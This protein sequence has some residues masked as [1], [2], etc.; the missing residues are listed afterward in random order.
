MSWIKM[1]T[2]LRDHPKVVRMGATL[3]A[4]RLRVIG[5]LWAVWSTF[6]THSI[7]GVLEGYT[8]SA[9][10][11]GIGWK[12]FA[13]AMQAVGWLVATESGLSVP[14]F[15]EHNGSSAKRRATDAKRKEVLRE[16][17]AGARGSWNTERQVSPLCPPSEVAE[18]A[19]GGGQMSASDADK[20]PPR[21]R[22][23]KEKEKEGIQEGS[24]RARPPKKP[25]GVPDQVWADWIALRKAKRA[26][27]TET[28]IAEAQSEARKAG[29]TLE[30]F[31]SVWCARGSQGLQ[32]D[33]LKPQ[34]RIGHAPTP[35]ETAYQRSARERLAEMTGGL[36]SRA[37][38]NA[39][40]PAAQE[41]D[42]GTAPRLLA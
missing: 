15:D 10:D 13:K 18:R 29:M 4:D 36:V 27:V 21:E 2:E 37:D 12:S 41:S 1:R 3:K 33:W 19:L 31:L 40:P 34:E 24:A 26:P 8:L 16:E 6:D 25:E 42:D 5:G 9:L 11:E 23:E 17:D 28:V 30:A 7:D 22:V 38:P 35:S 32:A 39:P 14:E 20:K